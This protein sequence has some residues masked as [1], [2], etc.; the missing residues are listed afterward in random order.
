[1]DLNGFWHFRFDRGAVLEDVADP[2]FE[3]ND[4]LNVPGCFDV[5][6]K[7]NKQRGT[8]QYRKVIS[9]DSPASNAFWCIDGMGLRGRFYVDG[10]E[11]GYS[12]VPYS[13][14]V[15]PTGP[16]SAGRHV[17]SVALDNNFN[18]EK[19]KL[20]L[21]F[22]DFYAFGGFYHGMS[23]KL[24]TNRIQL[25][26]VI[27][28]TKDYKKGIVELELKALGDASLPSKFNAFVKFDDNEVA[29]VK[30]EKGKSIVSVP[31]FKIWSPEMP[32][33]HT[34][35][36]SYS[37]VSVK[38]RFGLRSIEVCGQDILLN[39]EKIFLK[40]VNRHESHPTFGAATPAQLMQ[41]DIS[42]IKELGANFIRCAH[43]QQS[44]AFLDMCDEAGLLVWEESLGWGNKLESLKDREFI[45]LQVRQTKAMVERSMNHPSIIIYAFLNEVKSNCKEGKSL[46]DTLVSTVKS[47][48][49]GRLTTFACH[50]TSDDIANVN[51]DIIA[52]NTY[53]GWFDKAD[54]GS[55]ESLENAI[56]TEVDR[57]IRFFRTKYNNKPIMISEIGMCGIY[58]FR[59]ETAPQWTENFQAEYIGKSLDYALSSKDLCGVAIWQ[60]ADADSYHRNGGAIR[61]KPFGINSAGI[62]DSFRRPKLV[63]NVVKEKYKTR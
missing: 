2:N 43:Y 13:Y 8:A 5:L 33:L 24:Q 32:N 60:F 20:F 56:T 39:G 42:L 22:Y 52:F 27:V 29:S 44:E 40:G 54:L 37:G 26:R 55:S 3:A 48:D 7:Y 51:T 25:D 23:L 12:N 38:S 17:L 11:I 46:V 57:I 63:V 49:S 21:P 30:F 14:I 59:D 10:K 16:L 41:S 36:V 58:G 35:Q 6:H 31:N 15:L 61:G 4:L 1:M 19:L 9:I 34:V 18:P 47:M 53:P 28:R 50:K 62:V 45:D